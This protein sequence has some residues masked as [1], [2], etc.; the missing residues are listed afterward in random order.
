MDLIQ[1]NNELGTQIVKEGLVPEEILQKILEAC[2]LQGKHL[3]STLLKENRISPSHLSDVLRKLGE[4]KAQAPKSEK[5]KNESGSP[6]P[7]NSM[8]IKSPFPEIHTRIGNYEILEKIARGGMGAIYKAYDTEKDRVVALKMLLSG[9]FASPSQIHRF[10]REAQTM[11]RLHHPNIIPVY[12]MGKKEGSLY[13][14]MK[15]IEGHTFEK[16]LSENKPMEEKINTLISICHALHHAHKSNIL[17]RDIKPSN[18]LIDRD[19]TPYLVDFGLAKVLDS[20]SRLTKSD[21][22]LGTP[23]YM[24]PEHTRDAKHMDCRSDV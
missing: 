11:S 23:Y 22:V 19:G 4:Y 2:N 3:G 6:A 14:T 16:S 13:L 8:S 15:Y 10:L 9:S 5:E 7:L 18:I 12:G 1:A 20:N 17:H 24:S 21:T